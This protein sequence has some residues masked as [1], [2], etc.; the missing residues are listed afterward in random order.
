MTHI[1]RL[2]AGRDC[3]TVVP[4]ETVMPLFRWIEWALLHKVLRENK[5]VD[6]MIRLSKRSLG[7]IT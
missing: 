3:P 5:R 4:S 6:A 7:R 1:P 2:R